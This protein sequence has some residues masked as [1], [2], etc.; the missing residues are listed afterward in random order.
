[1]AVDINACFMQ[2]KNVILVTFKEFWHCMYIFVEITGL[3]IFQSGF[4]KVQIK[5]I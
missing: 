3:N 2:N 1:M 5:P 4:C